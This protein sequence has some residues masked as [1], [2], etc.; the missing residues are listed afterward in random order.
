MPIRPSQRWFYPIDWAELSAAIRFGRARGRC[1]RCGRPHGQTVWHLSRAMVAGRRGLWWDTDWT[2]HRQAA[3]DAGRMPTD[4]GGMTADVRRA[5]DA[6]GDT[7][8]AVSAK[9]AAAGAWRCER[10]R[11]LPARV[12]APPTQLAALHRQLAFWPELERDAWPLRSPVALAC[13][14]LDHDPTNNAASNLAALCQHCHLEHDRADNR[15]RRLAAL[16]LRR[17][18]P[19]PLAML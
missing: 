2:S 14:H 15:A 9:R 5:A 19:T 8:D 16:R 11:A 6:R 13:C 4:A 1:E 12:L 17:I 10:G 18:G 7:G 3:P